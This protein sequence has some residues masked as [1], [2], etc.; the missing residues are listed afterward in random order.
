MN[1]AAGPPPL[2][3]P[4]PNVEFSEPE[5]RGLGGWLVL[6]GIGLIGNLYYRVQGIFRDI[7]AFRS[8][9]LHLMVDPNSPYHMIGFIP[10]LGLE[11]CGH[12]ALVVAVGLLIYFF[13]S[14]TRLFPRL[15]IAYLWAFAAFDACD[16]ALVRLQVQGAPSEH[17]RQSMIH[18][19][20]FR[21]EYQAF[22]LIGGA[23]LWTS[24]MLKSR[25]VQQTFVN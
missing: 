13:V 25:R 21:Q 3:D 5:L 1:A 10:L 7:H 19:A 2:T 17:F 12:V 23:I 4:E 24:Y 16:V 20:L 15:Y 22:V 11:F 6:V 8:S 14:K 18:G 9:S